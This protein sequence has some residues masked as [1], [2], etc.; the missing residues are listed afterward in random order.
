MA[1]EA[2]WLDVRN[3][4]VEKKK[5]KISFTHTGLLMEGLTR[6]SRPF[7]PGSISKNDVTQLIPLSVRCANGKL[8]NLRLRAVRWNE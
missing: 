6:C 5:R 2:A 4:R 1:T 8:P 3:P 7:A